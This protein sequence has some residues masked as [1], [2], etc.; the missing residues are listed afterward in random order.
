MQVLE[1]EDDRGHVEHSHALVEA[2]V[3]EHLAQ[4][5]RDARGVDGI[6]VRVVLDG[7]ERERDEAPVA[8]QHRQQLHLVPEPRLHAHLHHLRLAHHLDGVK[9]VAVL[10]ERVLGGRGARA[11]ALPG[12]VAHLGV[13]EARGL[14]LELLE[15]RDLVAPRGVLVDD[16]LQRAEHLLKGVL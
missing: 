3:G 12:E 9:L 13:G 7:R 10:G 2:A 4:A 15:Q 5:D 6:D 11:D 14:L 16:L 1:R 8:V